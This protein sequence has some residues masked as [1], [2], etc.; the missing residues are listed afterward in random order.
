MRLTNSLLRHYFA[1]IVEL[2]VSARY[3]FL[4]F[5]NVKTNVMSGRSKWLARRS[6][7]TSSP[8][9]VVLKSGVVAKTISWVTSLASLTEP[10]GVFL[11][12]PSLFEEVKKFIILNCFFQTSFLL[13]MMLV[14]PSLVLKLDVG[15][16]CNALTLLGGYMEANWML[17][18][19]FWGSDQVVLGS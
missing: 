1:F 6:S 12:R 17:M 19:T 16:F 11:Y 4:Q 2:N 7:G 3:G 9:D 14:F 5:L 15:L 18:R 13:V 8:P 10:E